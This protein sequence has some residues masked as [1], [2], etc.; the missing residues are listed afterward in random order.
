[1]NQKIK[2]QT[3]RQGVTF[4]FLIGTI[5]IVSLKIVTDCKICELEHESHFHNCNCSAKVLNLLAD[6]IELLL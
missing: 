4:F 5:S 6:V 3:R 2:F 1:M